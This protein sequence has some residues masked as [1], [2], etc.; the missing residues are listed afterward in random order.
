MARWRLVHGGATKR[1]AAENLGDGLHVRRSH[2][3][4]LRRQ[5]DQAKRCRPFTCVAREV[6]R[7]QQVVARSRRL[8]LERRRAQPFTDGSIGLGRLRRGDRKR[9][10]RVWEAAQGVVDLLEPHQPMLIHMVG[11]YRTGQAAGR[12][13][14]ARG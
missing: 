13:G 7:V 10:R 5:A 1:L 9:A 6:C 14:R 3:R 12:V 4:H 11:A 2:P 8:A